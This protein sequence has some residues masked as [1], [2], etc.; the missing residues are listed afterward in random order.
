MFYQTFVHSVLIP[1]TYLQLGNWFCR[2]NF[3]KYKNIVLT[4]EKFVRQ[5]CFLITNEFPEFEKF[6][7]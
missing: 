3:K 2:N 7:S 4:T 6:S 5:T 1:F